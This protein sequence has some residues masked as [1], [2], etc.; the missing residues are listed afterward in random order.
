MLVPNSLL[1]L[2]VSFII[3]V[4]ICIMTTD[5][6]TTIKD[7]FNNIVDNCLSIDDSDFILKQQPFM[8]D[9]IYQNPNAINRRGYDILDT[10]YNLKKV[11]PVINFHQQFRPDTMKYLGW[12]TWYLNNFC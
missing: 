12:R 1:L 2:V 7:K 5:I 4:L 8:D 10:K 9:I 11:G 6:G 3:I